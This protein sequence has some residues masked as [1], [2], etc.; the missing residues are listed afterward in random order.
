MTLRRVVSIWILAMAAGVVTVQA[1]FSS[2]SDGSD[3]PLTVSA[4]LTTL[5][6][7][8][9]GIFNFTTVTIETGGTLAFNKN[10]RNTPVHLLA[11]GDI[12][13]NANGLIHVNAGFGT[14]AAGGVGAPAASMEVGPASR[15]WRMATA[16]DREQVPRT[17][18]CPEMLPM[19]GLEL[20]V[21]KTAPSM[22]APC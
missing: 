18:A 3:G 8:D 10:V 17:R 7:P 1:Q 16:T 12:V 21:R 6:V 2:G 22:A 5:D 20:I 19:A 14:G 15:G 11:T 13:V 4:G 9:D